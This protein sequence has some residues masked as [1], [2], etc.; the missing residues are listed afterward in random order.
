MRPV[1]I[2]LAY[3]LIL[4]CTVSLAENTQ[5]KKL[6]Y[7]K[8]AGRGS[9][10]PLMNPLPTI[11]GWL[12]D[13]HYLL[14]QNDDKGIPVL[15]SI[16]AKDS[17]SAVYVSNAEL[18]KKLPFGFTIQQATEHSNDYVHF[19]FNQKNDLYY[20]NA[21]SGEFKQLTATPAIEYTPQFSPDYSKAAFTRDHDLFVVDIAT[22]REQQ[23]THDGSDVILNG[24]NSWVYFE[25]V[26]GRDWR[27]FWWAP[28][29][30]KIAFSRYDD[31]PV[32][33]FTLF[34]ADSVHGRL[35]TARYPKAGDPN[36]K[37]KLGVATLA[38][39]KIAWMQTDADAD[40]YL[41]FPF[42]RPDGK[43]LYF[44]CLNRGQDW[45]RI[46]LAD[47]SDSSCRSIYEERETT[48][49]E[50]FENVYVFNDGS[51]FILKSDKSGWSHLYYH[52]LQGRLRR[53]LTS[54]DWAVKAISLVDEK[55]KV[56][57]TANYDKSV[58]THLCCVGLNGKKFK[59]LTSATGTHSVKISPQASYFIDTWSNIQQPTVIELTSTQGKKIRRLGNAAGPTLA[60]YQ[61]GRAEL[62]TISN[63]DGYA[64]PAMWVLPVELDKNKKY[65]VLISCYGGPGAAEVSN[66]WRGLRSHYF[67][68]ND[69]IY[70]SV[71]HRG[72][73]H[74]GKKGERLMHRCLGRWEMNDYI[75]AVNW[76]RRLP[77][78]DSTRIAI[79]G[80]SYGG[81]VTCLALT[82]GAGYFT[83]G[84][85]EFSVTDYRL[86]DSMYTE[87]YMDLPFENHSGYD[88]TSVMTWVDRYKGLLRITHGTMDDN[89]HMQNSMQLIDKLQDAGKH[90]E[91]MLYPNERHGYGGSK[92]RHD[93]QESMRFWFRN[94]L[95]KEWSAEE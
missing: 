75:D 10:G 46:F 18:N 50:F 11:E 40:Q 34:C 83:H 25:E 3:L 72:A 94:L 23:L 55:N 45:L 6:T 79:T 87:R 21:K 31:S 22:G 85:A 41:A 1:K 63:S 9:G 74:F 59:R 95:N 35:E 14:Q 16:S 38:D 19:L 27:A 84:I 93:G 33:V 17:Q 20:F 76:L 26:Y 5:K 92:N 7:Q 80:G 30:D 66:S 28:T 43:Q 61:L 42:W 82:Y 56:Y 49:V 65:P 48:W 78:V 32:P 51:G 12:D 73:G 77:F 57:F 68:H 71:D 8:T 91:M 4:T 13:G 52:D 58:E 37:V 70:L 44:Q 29:S 2:F 64:M 89:V 36:P 54:G 47:L 90:F 69:I 86:Y 39:G 15:Y 67:A 60:E 24:Y 88:S 53:Q 81:Y 62:F